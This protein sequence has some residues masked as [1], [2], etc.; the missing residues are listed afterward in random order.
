MKTALLLGVDAKLASFLAGQLGQYG[1]VLRVQLDSG[2]VAGSAEPAYLL[3]RSDRVRSFDLP[4]APVILGGGV[5]RPLGE[6]SCAC[7]LLDSAARRAPQLAM[8]LGLPA[9]TCGLRSTDCFTFSSMDDTGGVFYV[10][11]PVR[12]LSGE[13]LE[14]FEKPVPNLRLTP[15]NAT[16][17]LLVCALL[18]LWGQWPVPPA[19]P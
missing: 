12:T 17:H 13:Y 8:R 15:Q 16:A 9:L 3:L 18:T 19:H 10:Q 5:R 2:D 4:D 14:P 7:C 11:R 1:P 6:L